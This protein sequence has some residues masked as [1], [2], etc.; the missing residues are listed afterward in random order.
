MVKQVEW[1]G[2]PIESHFYAA[3]LLKGNHHSAFLLARYIKDVLFNLMLII[4]FAVI[5]QLFKMDQMS[6]L[7]ACF[8]WC[9]TNPSFV[10]FV[11]YLTTWT[12]GAKYNIAQA[13]IILS[14]SI[15]F[16]TVFSFSGWLFSSRQFTT[17]GVIEVSI[18]RFYP[19]FIMAQNI[20]QSLLY[21]KVIVSNS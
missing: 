9:F 5:L 1:H 16:I 7:P 21:R 19:T 8:F 15:V 2:R 18:D 6:M 14:S 11:S 4:M 12:F 13:A 10:Y 20:E 17:L 3:S